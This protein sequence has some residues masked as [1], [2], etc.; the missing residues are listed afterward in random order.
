[1]Q[2]AV[3][4]L[5]NNEGSNPSAKVIVKFEKFLESGEDSR[6]YGSGSSTFVFIYQNKQWLLQSY[7]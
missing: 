2:N 5:Q 7:E 1:L 3:Y 6:S 4:G